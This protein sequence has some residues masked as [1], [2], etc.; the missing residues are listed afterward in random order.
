MLSGRISAHLLP[1]PPPPQRYECHYFL[2]LL[3]PSN[4][5]KL[6]LFS[7]PM[8]SSFPYSP[9]QCPQASLILPSNVLKLPLFSLPMSSSFPY[10]P[11]QCPQAFLILPSNVLKLPLFSLPMSSSFP[12][13]PFQYVPHY[14]NSLPNHPPS[15]LHPYLIPYS[16]CSVFIFYL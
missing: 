5:L 13:S 6:P 15:P 7:L 9:F 11:F 3:L 1:P 16:L 2:K 12:Y 14:T 4:V 8:S 10:S